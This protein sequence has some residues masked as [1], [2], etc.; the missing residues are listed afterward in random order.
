MLEFISSDKEFGIEKNCNGKAMGCLKEG[1]GSIG[2]DSYSII[3]F[4]VWKMRCGEVKDETRK[5]GKRQL[6]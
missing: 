2:F 3:L 5:L 4:S 6:Q 1:S